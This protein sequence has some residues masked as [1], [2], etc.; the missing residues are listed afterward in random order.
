MRGSRIEQSVP[1]SQAGYVRDQVS[2]RMS[3]RRTLGVRNLRSAEM[4]RV[5]YRTRSDCAT[6]V[7]IMLEPIL[8]S[9]S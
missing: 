3:A 1:P 8:H 4:P 7:L 5:F 6:A 2:Q 9:L